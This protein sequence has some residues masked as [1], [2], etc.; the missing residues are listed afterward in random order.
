M[1]APN[2]FQIEVLPRLGKAIVGGAVEARKLLIEMLCCLRQFRH[3]RADNARLLAERMPLL[4]VFLSEFLR[5]VAHVVKRGRRSSYSSRQDNLFAL[6]G[7]LL[8]AQHLRANRHRADRFFTEHDEFRADRPENRLIH[9]ALL[10]VL[11]LS[12]SSENQKLGQELRFVFTDVPPSQQPQLDFARVRLER[13]MDYYADALAWARLILNE[14]APVTGLGKHE[15][16]SLLFPMQAVFEA[17]VAKHLKRQFAGGL[18]VD[19]QVRKE[20][21]VLHREESWFR[22]Q[23][24]LLVRAGTENVLVLDSKW[25][26]L[27][28]ARSSGSDKYGLSQSDFYQ[29]HAYGQTYLNGRGDVV[30]IYPKSDAFSVPLETFEFLKTDVLRLWVL[31]FCLQ[32]RRL[33]VPADAPFASMLVA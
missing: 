31:P 4:E 26:L 33:V 28:G 2:G 23:P 1:Q 20:H 21:L 17:F 5:S 30:L 11:K 7:K 13:G 22:L 12:F 6:R 3:I 14:L 15:A 19:A 8:I 25:K 18:R 24:D 9:A 16:P 32:T 27:D 29:L 10:S